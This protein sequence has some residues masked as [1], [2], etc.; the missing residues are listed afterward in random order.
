MILTLM[1]NSWK[2]LLRDRGAQ[3]LAFVVPIAFFSIFAT[4]FGGG[5]GGGA[6]SGTSR[7]RVGIVDES[8]T[9]RSAALVAALEA[10]SSLRVILAAAAAG[11]SKDAPKTAL[12]RERATEMVR[13]GDL[14]TALVLPAGIDTSLMRFDGAGVRAVVLR[15][16]SDPVGSRVVTGLLQ[17]AVLRVSG[18]G[19]EASG[20][21]GGEFLPLH[22]EEQAVLG[23]KRENPMVAFYAAGIAVLFIMFSAAGAGGVLIEE[24]ESGTLERVL[25]SGLGMNGLLLAKWL[26][27]TSLACVQIVVMFVWGMVAFKLPLLDHLPGFALITV[28][29]AAAAAAFGLVLATLARTRQQLSG[30]ANL[31]VLSMNALGGSLFPRFLMSESLQKFSL[32]GFNAWALDGFLKVFWRNEPLAALL[33]Q[34]AA[35]AGFTVLFLFLARRIA[36]RWEIA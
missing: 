1:Q 29:T 36:V 27:V 17:R 3:V 24:N 34:V 21:G 4:I 28:S 9:E 14:P 32:V 12:T 23:E 19:S 20:G 15:D 2:A 5:S 22:V 16:P 25:T 10:D 11:S 30:L 13:Q 18:F 7:V 35:L 31:L 33:P 8:H 26:Y 6:L